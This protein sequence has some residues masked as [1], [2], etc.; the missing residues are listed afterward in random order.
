MIKTIFAISVIMKPVEQEGKKRNCHT[1]G[2]K[3]PGIPFFCFG[4][5]GERGRSRISDVLGVY[6]HGLQEERFQLFHISRAI[7]R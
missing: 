6:G 4:V 3:P 2:G 1:P 7:L 5:G